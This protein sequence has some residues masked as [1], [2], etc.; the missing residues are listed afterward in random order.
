MPLGVSGALTL[1]SPSVIYARLKTVTEAPEP[2]P[3]K[4][5][6]FSLFISPERTPSSAQVQ[7]DL[8]VHIPEELCNSAVFS[9]L[10]LYRLEPGLS[11]HLVEMQRMDAAARV[12]Y[13]QDPQIARWYV[14]LGRG[15]HAARHAAD[16]RG[17][18]LTKAIRIRRSGCAANAA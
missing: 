1:H 2:L 15:C 16:G 11:W 8:S 18:K 5:V 7:V 4:Y 17:V 14:V 6:P 12:I 9:S 10:A 3:R 13:A